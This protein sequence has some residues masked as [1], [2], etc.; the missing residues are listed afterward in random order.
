MSLGFGSS[1]PWTRSMMLRG[2]SRNCEQQWLPSRTRLLKDVAQNYARHSR[3]K[4]LTPHGGKRERT[5]ATM[6]YDYADLRSVGR[7]GRP[8]RN[9]IRSLEK[10]VDKLERG[11]EHVEG[12]SHSRPG[13]GG[14]R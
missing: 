1:R 10:R 9:Y 3:A 5:K 4:L 14:Q 12:Q 8:E 2:G 11:R 13:G 7:H 6:G